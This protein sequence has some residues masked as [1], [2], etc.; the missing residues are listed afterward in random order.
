MSTTNSKAFLHVVLFAL[1]LNAAI[2][3]DPLFYICSSTSGN[4]TAN[5]PYASNLDQLETY[6]YYQT[7]WFGF[8]L[9]AVGSTPDQA[10]GLANCRGDVNFTTCQTCVAE[11]KSTIS[12]LCP[13]NKGGIIWYDFCELKY[14]NS[15]F[16]HKIDTQNEFFLLNVNNVSNPVSFNAKTNELLSLLSEQASLSPR[17]F[18]TGAASFDATTTIYGLAQCTRDLS[19]PDCKTCLD[20]AISQL[21][22]CCSGKQGGRV[23]GG[24][25]NVRYEIYPFVN[26]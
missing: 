14:S 20:E 23:V 10:Y 8:A 18:A 16:F 9:G 21:P 25:C 15:D 4:F 26:S 5:G 1:F 22:S 3:T 2:G 24:S 6:L 19:N 12:Q 17:L 7:P 13:S 11:A